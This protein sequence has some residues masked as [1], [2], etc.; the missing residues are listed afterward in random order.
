MS[1]SET[2]SIPVRRKRTA[3]DRATANGDPLVVRK[4]ARE[5][6]DKAKKVAQVFFFLVIKKKKQLTVLNILESKR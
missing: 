5:A 2:S 1:F 6:E 3:T 4:K